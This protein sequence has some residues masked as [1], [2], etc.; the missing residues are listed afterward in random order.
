MPHTSARQ[1]ERKRER[2]ER[3]ASTVVFVRNF[4]FN[5]HTLMEESGMCR[6]MGTRK[7]RRA[8]GKL[9]SLPNV[10]FAFF[11]K[12]IIFILPRDRMFV[13]K[14]FSASVLQRETK[15]FFV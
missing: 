3:A 12:K 13:M 6:H 2:G 14:F 11:E 1:R 8:R 4:H 10:A 15:Q 7:K 5:A 9:L